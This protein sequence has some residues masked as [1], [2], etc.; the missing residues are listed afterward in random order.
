MNSGESMRRNTRQR[1]VILEAV[2]ELG[3]HPTAE[4]VFDRVRKELPGTSMSTVYRNLGILADQGLIRALQ[5]TGR[6][7]HYDHN[8]R[9]HC[10]ITCSECGRICDVDANLLDKYMPSPEDLS[11]FRL[12]E[13]CINLVGICPECSVKKGKGAE[14]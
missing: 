4:Q 14:E 6:E 12:Q 13:V 8:N 3:C 2:R 1:R 11:G 7:T 5:G 9:K 10:H